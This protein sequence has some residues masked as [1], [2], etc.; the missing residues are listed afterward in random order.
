MCHQGPEYNKQRVSELLAWVS[1]SFS[2]IRIPT[3]LRNLIITSSRSDPVCSEE[4]YIQEVHLGFYMIYL[5]A[6]WLASRSKLNLGEWSSVEQAGCECVRVYGEI[7]TSFE[8]FSKKDFSR[9]T[10]FTMQGILRG[11]MGLF[12]VIGKT[13]PKEE[14]GQLSPPPQL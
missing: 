6:C 3:S 2:F 13:A 8:C 4:Y 10:C 14:P 12:R 11:I 9:E 1:L 5:W 7:Y